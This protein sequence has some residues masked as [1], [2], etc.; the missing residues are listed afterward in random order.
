[1]LYPLQTRFEGWSLLTEQ[2]HVWRAIH[3]GLI[4]VY[5]VC[6]AAAMWGTLQSLPEIYA[7]VTQEFFQAAWPHR[8]WRFKPIQKVACAYIFVTTMALVWSRVEFDILTQIAGF[9]LANLAIAV[10]MG[11]GLYLDR[12]LP[13]PHRTR[14]W[15][16]AGSV[17]SGAILAMMAGVS[18]WGLLTQLL[19][20]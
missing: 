3:P 10:M 14:R 4:W 8:Q 19:G 20:R 16:L 15:V 5:Y 2:A 12:Q 18:G 9:L 11:A 7:R 6:I 13:R 17:L 1:V